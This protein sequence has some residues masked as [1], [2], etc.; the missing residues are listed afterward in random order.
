MKLKKIMISVIA[1]L[2]IVSILGGC[3]MRNKVDDETIR[4]EQNRMVN[5]LA[6]HYEGIEQV[7]FTSF[8]K[9]TSTRTWVANAIVNGEIYVT[10]GINSLDNNSEINF[11]QHISQSNGQKLIEKETFSGFSNIKNISIKYYIGD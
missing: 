5:Y 6:D 11:G 9:N 4:K 8:E 10:F 7:E 3:G 2:G 1:I